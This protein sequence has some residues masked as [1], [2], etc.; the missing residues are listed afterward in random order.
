MAHTTYTTQ[1][2]EMYAEW[3]AP[4]M[5][6][7]RAAGI[8]M[9]GMIGRTLPGFWFKDLTG[10]QTKVASFPLE[11]YF[12]GYDVSEDEDHNVAQAYTPT[13]ATVTVSEK[14]A[15][16][17][18]TKMS[19]RTA[20]QDPVARAGRMLGQAIAEKLSGDVYA[21]HTSFDNESGTS[22]SAATWPLLAAARNSLETR[23]YR[24]PYA[25]ILK[26][27]Q[28]YDIVNGGTVTMISGT[29]GA[30]EQIVRN[31]DI[32]PIGGINIIRDPLIPSANSGADWSGAVYSGRPA[33]GIAIL[34]ELEPDFEH[35]ASYRLDQFVA[36]MC[37]GVGE[38]D[39]AAAN[40]YETD[41][42]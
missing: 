32:D 35:D 7:A 11:N 42:A 16:E 12:T 34:W 9:P 33:V 13:D 26:P 22:G 5:V 20:A 6:A 40:A 4:A 25:A 18:V 14:I 41:Y 17:V 23:N 31:Y 39:G 19:S 21:L 27:R 37:Y 38:I 36:T 15:I 2:S 29:D 1:G 24:G 10:L 8:F 30:A 3:I 28:Y